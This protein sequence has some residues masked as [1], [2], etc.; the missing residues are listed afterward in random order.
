[1]IIDPVGQFSVGGNNMT[2]E[3]FFH[4][5]EIL[6]ITTTWGSYHIAAKSAIYSINM[7]Y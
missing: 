2:F 3:R 7:K 4:A 1:M 5:L 6:K